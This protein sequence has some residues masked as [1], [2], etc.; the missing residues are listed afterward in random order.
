[1][2]RLLNID[3][4]AEILRLK[5]ATVLWHLSRN[6]G[7]LPPAVRVPGGRGARWRVQ[8]VEK[9]LESHVEH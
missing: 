6:P 5:R 9:W 1:M 4:L 3:E 7:R 8:D 2:E